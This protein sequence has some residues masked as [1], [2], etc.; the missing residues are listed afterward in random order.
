MQFEQDGDVAINDIDSGLVFQ[1][2]LRDGPSPQ[3]GRGRC[4]W[5]LP[6][7]LRDKLNRTTRLVHKILHPSAL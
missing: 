3:Q 7:D 5:V 2:E 6:K 4:L 1:G